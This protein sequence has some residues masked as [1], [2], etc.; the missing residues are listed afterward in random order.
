MVSKK[1]IVKNETGLHLRPAGNLCKLALK[2]PC[3][4]E[5]KTESRAVNAKSVLGLLSA[6]VKSGE[7]VEI[8]CDG[9]K[10]EEA[11]EKIIDAIEGGL[12]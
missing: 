5:L 1:V 3:K 2:Y 9:E 11:L 6:G 8:V 4:I 10:E 7:C 12:I